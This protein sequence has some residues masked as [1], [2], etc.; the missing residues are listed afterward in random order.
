MLLLIVCQCFAAGVA[1]NAGHV[2]VFFYL[3]DFNQ[4]YLSGRSRMGAAA[5]DAVGRR[6]IGKITDGH[7]GD[8]LVEGEGFA[9][10]Q[11]FRFLAGIKI[12]DGNRMIIPDHLIGEKL[13]LTS[14]FRRYRGAVFQGDVDGHVVLSHVE[15]VISAAEEAVKRAGENVLAAVSLHVFEPSVP[16]QGAADFAALR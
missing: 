10:R 12:G 7:D 16:V 5:G 14:H 3:V 13:C 4:P 6:R 15:S 9:K 8:G 2:L 1:I 11:L